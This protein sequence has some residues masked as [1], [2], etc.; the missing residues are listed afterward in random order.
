MRGRGRFIRSTCW[1]RPMREKRSLTTS[2]YRQPRLQADS[3]SCPDTD[4][5]SLMLHAVLMELEG[6]IADTRSARRSALKASVTVEGISLSDTEYDDACVGMPVRSAIRA[7]LA[8]HGIRDD[9]TRVDLATL[10]AERQ[11]ASHVESGVSLVPGAVA[12]IESLH[13]HTRL[14]IVS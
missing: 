1:T 4:Y 5:L 2:G 6:V 7:A 11:F 8:L 13:G 14:G 10:R 9:E 12:L 3:R